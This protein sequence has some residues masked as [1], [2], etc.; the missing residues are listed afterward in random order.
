MILPVVDDQGRSYRVL[1][2]AIHY[3]GEPPRRALAPPE[4]GAHT[5]EVLR[6]WLTLDEETIE[7]LHT[8]GAIA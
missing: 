5:D 6:D 4:I 1:A 2:S 8:S 7:A 3:E